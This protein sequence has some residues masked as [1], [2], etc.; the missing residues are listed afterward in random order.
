MKTWSK[1]F[2]SGRYIDEVLRYMPIAD[3]I[4]NEKVKNP[5]ILDVGSGSTGIAKFIEGAVI[6]LD[7][8]FNGDC[9]QS[10]IQVKGD[11]TQLPFRDKSFDYVLSVDNV[12]HIKPDL[13]PKLL[14]EM[15]RVCRKKVF[16]AVPC[17]TESE[18][19]DRRLDSLFL[20]EHGERY[21]FLIEHVDYGLPTAEEI[22]EIVRKSAQQQRVSIGKMSIIPNVNLTVRYMYMRLWISRYKNLQRLYQLSVVM[23]HFRRWLNFGKCYRMIFMLELSS[24]RDSGTGF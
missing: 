17:G 16:L 1:R 13:R 8:A 23:S 10:L 24:G 20:K 2:Y 6:G 12:E 11:G 5:K 22:I 18:A 9:I 14:A 4:R 3:Y 21:P 19:Q 15:L 7:Q